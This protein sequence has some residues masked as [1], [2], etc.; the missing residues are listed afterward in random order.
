MQ[1]SSGKE[2]DVEANADE[3]VKALAQTVSG[4]SLQRAES[5]EEY[6][7]RPDCFKTTFQECLFVLTATL[8]IAQSSVLI[9]ATQV[10]TAYIAE[11]LHMN[12]S[13]LTWLN[14]ASS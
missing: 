7:K 11:D 2:K 3:T 6:G 14:A 8:A 9:G 12:Q 4:G 10:I 1:D 13:E 5:E